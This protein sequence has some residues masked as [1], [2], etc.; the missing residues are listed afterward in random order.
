M[1]EF[2]LEIYVGEEPAK[3]Y[4]LTQED[5]IGQVAEAVQAI[6]DA[7]GVIVTVTRKAK[8]AVLAQVTYSLPENHA[9]Y[10]HTF[11]DIAI[12]YRAGGML[13]EVQGNLGVQRGRGTIAIPFLENVVH[14]ILEALNAPGAYGTTEEV[15]TARNA[16][17]EQKN[18]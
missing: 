2:L 17:K 15:I 4:L 10:Y 16:E 5:F 18:A 14:D 13:E 9:C 12:C 1:T 3:E 7:C 6:P 11:H 8:D